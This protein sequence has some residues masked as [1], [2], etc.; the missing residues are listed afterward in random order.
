M[1]PDTVEVSRATVTPDGVAIYDYNYIHPK[2][3][4]IT[5][6]WHPVINL[7]NGRIDCDCPHYGFTLRRRARTEGQKIDIGRPRYQ[8]KHLHAAIRDCID[9]GEITL[10]LKGVVCDKTKEHVAS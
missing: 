3:G 6:V 9:R 7:N 10:H 4:E 2:T 8:C 5:K 1:K